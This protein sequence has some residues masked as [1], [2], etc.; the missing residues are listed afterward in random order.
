MFNSL[1]LTIFFL[2]KI[3]KDCFIKEQF[4]ILIN[5]SLLNEINDLYFIFLIKR[6][7]CFN[8]KIIF[9]NNLLIHYFVFQLD[10]LKFKIYYVIIF[11]ER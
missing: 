7:N 6:I 3:F 8:N 10:Q 9:N 11:H 5:A 2:L 1:F 4:I